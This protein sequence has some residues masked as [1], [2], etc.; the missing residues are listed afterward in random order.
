MN[1]EQMVCKFGLAAENYITLKI[2]AI[3][4]IRKNS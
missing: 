4:V 1:S 2:I 3:L